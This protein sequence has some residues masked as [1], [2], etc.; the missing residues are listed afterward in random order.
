[1]KTGIRQ[2]AALFADAYREL[3]AKKLFWITLGFSVVVAAAL[4]VL[5][6]SE[7]GLT[8]LHWEFDHSLLNSGRIEPATF[9][10][11]LFSSFYIRIWLTWA[12][13]ILALISTA[14]IF[15]DF[16]SG[17]AI[18]LTLSKP[19]SRLRLFLTKYATGLLFAAL[20]VAAFTVVSFLVI[21]IRGGAWEFGLF[22]A[23]PLVVLFFS[24]LF[25]IAVLLGILT[26]STIASLLLTLLVWTVVL[27]GINFADGQVVSQR[28]D[29]Q[30]RLEHAEQVLE[31][32]DGLPELQEGTRSPRLAAAEAEASDARGSF[33]RWRRWEGRFFLAKTILPKTSETMDLLSRS[34]LRPDEQMAI[35][36]GIGGEQAQLSPR[37][38]ELLV[39]ADRSRS[40]WWIIGTSLSFEGVLVGLAAWI[41][42]RRDF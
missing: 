14:A 19:I 3:N 22:L 26:R 1:M 16:I 33:E 17:G 15:P 4:G 27:F 32:Q 34:L 24:Y 30:L 10:K 31:A 23:V 25:S 39:E 40:L 20:Q 2:T 35:L 41:F 36:T 21:G 42:I 9:Y 37:H 11:F 12:A 13:T 7:R 6:L 18:E 29:A 8:L 5:G 28:I 38:Q